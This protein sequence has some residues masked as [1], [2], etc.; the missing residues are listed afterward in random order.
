MNINVDPYEQAP[1][2]FETLEMSLG[3]LKHRIRVMDKGVAM[4]DL[5]T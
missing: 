1:Q 2:R 3:R 4:A 5:L